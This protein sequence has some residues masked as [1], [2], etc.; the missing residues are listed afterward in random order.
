MWRRPALLIALALIA[1]ACGGSAETTTTSSATTTTQAALEPTGDLPTVGVAAIEVPDQDELPMVVYAEP[2]EHGLDSVEIYP[3]EASGA[4]RLTAWGSDGTPTFATIEG[5][6]VTLESPEVG[7]ARIELQGDQALVE[8]STPEGSGSETIPLDLTDAP[9]AAP[10]INA[11]AASYQPSR[12]EGDVRVQNLPGGVIL[13]YDIA[14]EGRNN[15]G[16]DLSVDR[17]GIPF[18]VDDIVINC[19]LEEGF[20]FG[21]RGKATLLFEAEVPV[22][23]IPL[24]TLSDEQR[25]SITSKCVDRLNAFSNDSAIIAQTLSVLGVPVGILSAPVGALLGVGAVVFG[26]VSFGTAADSSPR[27]CQEQ[28]AS[29]EIQVAA[30]N[31]LQGLR[32]DGWVLGAQPDRTGWVIDNP[33]IGIPTFEPFRAGFSD[34]EVGIFVVD[35]EPEEPD[36]ETDEPE[37]QPTAFNVGDIEFAEVTRDGKLELASSLTGLVVTYDEFLVATVVGQLQ[38]TDRWRATFKCFNPGESEPTGDQATVRYSLAYQTTFVGQAQAEIDGGFTMTTDYT[39]PYGVVFELIEPFEAE[40]QHLN[41]DDAPG[42]GAFEPEGQVTIT[43]KRNGRVTVQ[44]SWRGP[45]IVETPGIFADNVRRIE[46]FGRADGT[47]TFE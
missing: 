36:E 7:T 24:G 4:T 3:T 14:G 10:E 17:C 38:G 46:G 26:F 37:P 18:A 42:I 27:E 45:E 6:I 15:V 31:R 20:D 13:R 41:S 44:T 34:L 9:Q 5:D 28:V 47:F 16:L 21:G 19:R 25:Q 32:L 40:C 29:V 2:G 39:V 23:A 33:G 11:I 43:V 12:I 30:W 35:A 8:W 1:S 22:T